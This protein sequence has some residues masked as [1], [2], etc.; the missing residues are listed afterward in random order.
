[1]RI[2]SPM[3]LMKDTRI[4][5]RND[6]LFR[7]VF[8]EAGIGIAILDRTGQ[9]IEI[10]PALDAILSQNQL[11]KF[12]QILP[13]GLKSLVPMIDRSANGLCCERK[14]GTFQ[15]QDFW[16]HVTVSAVRDEAGQ[17]LHMIAIIEDISAHKQSEIV[18]PGVV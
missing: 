14:L 5:S 8:T 16:I 3:T 13:E 15:F 1:M 12:E 4:V 9:A 6:A 10:N 18:S 11:L 17:I 2:D 7:A